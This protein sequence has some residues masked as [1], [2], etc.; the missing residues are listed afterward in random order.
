MYL[1]SRDFVEITKYCLEKLRRSTSQKMPTR[2]RDISK[3]DESSEGKWNKGVSRA[4]KSFIVERKSIAIEE[5]G[6]ESLSSLKDQDLH[7]F[8]ESPVHPAEQAASSSALRQHFDSD[9]DRKSDRPNISF[10]NCEGPS[11]WP[12][13][14]STTQWDFVIAKGP[15]KLDLNYEFPKEAASR[16]LSSC[17]LQRKL[18]NGDVM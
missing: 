7:N 11:S 1:R 6:S 9:S 18:S 16:K 14:F 13:L 12:K 17:L 10:F 3:E 15:H 8:P 4:M 2:K 5:S